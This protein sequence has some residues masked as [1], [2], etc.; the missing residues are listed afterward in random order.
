[1]K[2]NQYHKNIIFYL[3]EKKGANTIIEI[4]RAC[5]GQEYRGKY[6]KAMNELIKTNQVIKDE[7]GY[8][9][10]DKYLGEKNTKKFI[11]S[12]EAKSILLFNKQMFKDVL[13][14][15][16]SRELLKKLSQASGVVDKKRLK[17]LLKE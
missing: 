7:D 11:K 6:S 16:K 17:E 13:R 10:N 3:I 14:D 9:I 5:E 1:M 4:A 8:K 12:D 2:G 15:K